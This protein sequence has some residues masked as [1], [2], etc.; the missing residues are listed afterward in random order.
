MKKIITSA[1]LIALG[2]SANVSAQD[3]DMSALLNKVREGRVTESAEHRAREAEFQARREDQQQLL[4]QAQQRQQVLERESARLEEERRN[5]EQEITNQLEIQRERLGQLSEL[6]GVLQQAAGD[7]RSV[8]STSHISI[9]NEGRM[10]EIDTLV[11]KAAESSELPTLAE[12]RAWPAQMMLEMIGSGEVKKF[13]YEV[14]LND[15][16]TQQMDI[17]RVG[18]F[19]LVGDGKFLQLTTTG[20]VAELQ[21][22]PP[23]YLTGTIA[24]FEAATSGILGLG[25]DPTRGQ[26]LNLEVEKPDVFERLEQGG[27]IGYLTLSLGAIGV[28]LAVF[29]WL[30][31]FGVN[32]KVKK[33][34]KSEVANVNNPL[35]RVLAVYDQNR[36]VDVETL[37]LKLDEAILKETPALERFLTVIKLISAVAPLFGLLGT[38]TGMIE[39]FQAITLFGTGDPSQMAGGISAA[40]MTTVEGLVVAI[41]TLL[42]HSFVS[43]SSKGVVHILEEQSAGIIAVHA[44]KEN[45]NASA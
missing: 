26:L 3:A 28:L 21:K 39:T 33:Q 13:N 5:N 15:G 37:E 24:P 44:E 36:N 1:A 16:T 14:R 9:D 45:A 43:G 11:S 41:P 10:A 7:A 22:Q 23:G 20:E 29:Q 35:G 17:V 12:I 30:Y 19:G 4:Q 40:L 27:F 32:S 38:V 42:L 18:D 25:I 31:L 34:V 8:I 6:F 2:L